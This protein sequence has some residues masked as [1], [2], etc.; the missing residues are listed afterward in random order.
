MWMFTRCS[1]NLCGQV[2]GKEDKKKET[3]QKH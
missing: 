1:R 3:V 2:K